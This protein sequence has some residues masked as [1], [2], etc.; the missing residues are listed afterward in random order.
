M[1]RWNVKGTFSTEQPYPFMLID[2]TAGK[3]AIDQTPVK[4]GDHLLVPSGYGTLKI[5]GET[6]LIV[7]HTS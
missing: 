3:G 6:E 1:F 2:V 4:A 5:E 7:T